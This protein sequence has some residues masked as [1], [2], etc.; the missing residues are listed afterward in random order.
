[1]LMKPRPARG[2]GLHG[3]R[4]LSAASAKHALGASGCL[5]S[6][7]R[8]RQVGPGRRA[9]AASAILRADG[10]LQQPAGGLLGQR[11]L[12]P[13][14]DIAAEP[15]RRLGG[16]AALERQTSQAEDRVAGP[17]GSAGNLA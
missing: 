10:A 14:G 3:V 17:G 6:V 1:M 13:V 9:L 12:G 4:K 16:T 7:R 2:G 11:A 5:R 15:A 8:A